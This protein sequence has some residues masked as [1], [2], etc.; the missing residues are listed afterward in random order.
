MS[1]TLTQLLIHVVFSTKDRR[2]LI[3]PDVEPDMHAYLGGICRDESS[4]A[5][6]IGGTANHVHL[7]ISL[8]KSVAMSDLM[9]AVKKNSSK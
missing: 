7:L 9:L 3:T 1:R 2:N 6:T 4:P 8:G 5:L